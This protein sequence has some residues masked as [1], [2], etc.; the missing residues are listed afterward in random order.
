MTFLLSSSTLDF[1]SYKLTGA[2]LLP[3]IIPVQPL[4]GPLAPLPLPPNSGYC[5]RHA[6]CYMHSE[7]TSGLWTVKTAFTV[8]SHCHFRWISKEFT[9][10]YYMCT[11]LMRYNQIN[12][13]SLSY[14][15]FNTYSI[16]LHLML[17]G[18]MYFFYPLYIFVRKPFIKIC[19]VFLKFYISIVL[20]RV[21]STFKGNSIQ[22]NC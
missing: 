1:I 9:H 6:L 11:R 20:L 8:K 15:L 13:Q 2:S 19:F 5:L 4:H 3:S 17:S 21:F 7:Y 10:M 16:P 18:Q 22:N 14:L 12:V